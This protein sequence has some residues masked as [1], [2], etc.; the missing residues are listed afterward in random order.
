MEIA[1]GLA[2]PVS[3]GTD[4]TK[5]FD[6]TTKAAGRADQI[7]QCAQSNGCAACY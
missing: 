4:I 5:N 1:M 6:D 2:F 7:F 3:D